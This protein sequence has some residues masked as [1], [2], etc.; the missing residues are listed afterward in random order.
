MQWLFCTHSFQ[1]TKYF[2]HLI[3]HWD[4]CWGKCMKYIELVMSTFTYPHSPCYLYSVHMQHS[5]FRDASKELLCTIFLVSFFNYLD[6]M[7]ILYIS[8]MLH[9]TE[10][11]PWAF[12]KWWEVHYF[13][14]PFR[15]LKWDPPHQN[16]DALKLCPLSGKSVGSSCWQCGPWFTPAET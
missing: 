10:W 13:K 3:P 7:A 14:A 11:F 1:F 5:R 15:Q 12:L 8:I 16:S 9:G 2:S 6:E 4:F